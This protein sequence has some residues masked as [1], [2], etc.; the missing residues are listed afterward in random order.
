MLHNLPS[1]NSLAD[2]LI[3]IQRSRFVG[4]LLDQK[5]KNNGMMSLSV[6]RN[7]TGARKKSECHFYYL[8]VQVVKKSR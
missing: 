3:S 5:P 1:Q 7:K 6:Y 4:Q 8:N 2:E